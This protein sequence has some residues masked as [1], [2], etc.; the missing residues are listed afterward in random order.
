MVVRVNQTIAVEIVIDLLVNYFL[1][2][3]RNF[4]QVRNWTIK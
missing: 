2:Q 1:C 3:L 4:G